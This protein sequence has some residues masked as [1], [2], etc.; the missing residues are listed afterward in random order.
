MSLV[1]PAFPALVFNFIFFKK[2]QIDFG[3]KKLCILKTCGVVKTE[4]SES[5]T[6]LQGGLLLDYKAII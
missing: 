3:E 5:K 6:C 1:L 4:V 2:S